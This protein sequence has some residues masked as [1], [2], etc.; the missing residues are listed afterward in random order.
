VTVSR[1]LALLRSITRRTRCFVEL[2]ERIDGRFLHRSRFRANE[3]RGALGF[4]DC[5]TGGFANSGSRL[6][7]R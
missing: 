7:G 3:L 5:A 6:V 1:R 2:G 4:G